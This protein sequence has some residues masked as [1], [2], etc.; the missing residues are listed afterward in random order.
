MRRHVTR[1]VSPRDKA[2]P[3]VRPH[4]LAL[5]IALPLLSCASSSSKPLRVVDCT[6]KEYCGVLDER[7][8]ASWSKNHEALYWRGVRSILVEMAC[9]RTAT[10]G[11][12]L[13]YVAEDDLP[14]SCASGDAQVRRVKDRSD[15]DR[16]LSAGRIDFLVEF[17]RANASKVRGGIQ[18]PISASYYGRPRRSGKDSRLEAIYTYLVVQTDKVAE[19]RLVSRAAL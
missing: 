7:P 12:K 10:R 9:G 6:Q 1:S 19:V 15:A 18:L 2:I 14:V 5:F 13:A 8:D 16:L 4:L 3:M 17:E 11:R